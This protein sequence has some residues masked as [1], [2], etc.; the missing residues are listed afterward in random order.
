MD[1]KI[2]IN[3]TKIVNFKNNLK[4]VKYNSKRKMTER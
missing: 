1:I 3:I 2:Q 4:F